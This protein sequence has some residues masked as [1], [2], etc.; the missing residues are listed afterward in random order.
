M[1]SLRKLVTLALRPRAL[2]TPSTTILPRTHLLP[3]NAHRSFTCTTRLRQVSQQEKQPAAEPK[4]ESLKEAVRANEDWIAAAAASRTVDA[5]PEDVDEVNPVTPALRANR[6]AGRNAGSSGRERKEGSDRRVQD[7]PRRQSV[8][9]KPEESERSPASKSDQAQSPLAPYNRLME[10][11]PEQLSKVSQGELI[12][13]LRN[14][15]VLSYPSPFIAEKMSQLLDHIEKAGLPL[16]EAMLSYL[17]SVYAD[18]GNV[19]KTEEVFQHAKA[20]GMRPLNS[21]VVFRGRAKGYSGDLAGAEECVRQ[22]A[23]GIGSGG[24]VSAQRAGE[25]APAL[26]G[27]FQSV[28]RYANRTDSNEAMEWVLRIAETFDVTF[29]ERTFNQLVHW[30]VSKQDLDK[31]LLFLRQ[32]HAMGFPS[33]KY[34]YTLVMKLAVKGTPAATPAPADA[35]SVPAA[36]EAKVEKVKYPKLALELYREMMASDVSIDG[37]LLALVL[38]SYALLDDHASAFR[39]VHKY[40]GGTKKFDYEDYQRFFAMAVVRA[41]PEIFDDLMGYYEKVCP[42]QKTLWVVLEDLVRG[43]PTLTTSDPD[44]ILISKAFKTYLQQTP[45]AKRSFKAFVA[46]IRSLTTRGKDDE[47]LKVL[48]SYEEILPSQVHYGYNTFIGHKALQGKKDE[49]FALLDEMKRKQIRVEANA[50]GLAI[51]AVWQSGPLNDDVKKLL[52]SFRECFFSHPLRQAQAKAAELVGKLKPL[53]LAFEEIGG[54]DYRKGVERFFS[55]ARDK[56]LTRHGMLSGKKAAE[57]HAPLSAPT[58]LPAEPD[59]DLSAFDER[60]WKDE[61]AT[62][63]GDGA[64]GGQASGVSQEPLKLKSPLEHLQ[65]SVT[66]VEEADSITDA[67]I[68][69][70]ADEEATAFSKLFNQSVAKIEKETVQILSTDDKSYESFDKHFRGLRSEMAESLKTSLYDMELA[71]KERLR[72]EE[73]RKRL[74]EEEEI[75]RRHE[76]MAKAARAKVSARE[77]AIA[78]GGSGQIPI[79]YLTKRIDFKGLPG[80]LTTKIS[81]DRLEHSI[82]ATQIRFLDYLNG[83]MADLGQSDVFGGMLAA[84]SSYDVKHEWDQIHAYSKLISKERYNRTDFVQLGRRARSVYILYSVLYDKPELLPIL[85]TGGIELTNRTA[86]VYFTKDLQA[87]M[88]DIGEQ[89]YWWLKPKF[90]NLHDLHTYPSGRGIV[91]AVGNNHFEM[92]LSTIASLRLVLGI[93]LPIEVWYAG[94]SDLS[95]ADVKLLSRFK[96]VR[97]M[98]IWEYFD[99]EAKEIGG[100]AI[101]PWAVLASSFKEVIL[102]DAE[103]NFLQNPESVIERSEIFRKYGQLFYRDRTTGSSQ[104]KWFKSFISYPSNYAKN[105]RYLQGK[106]WHEMES[107]VV[108]VDKGR[109]GVFHGLLATCKLNSKIERDEN[110]YKY[111][112]G[113]KE[114]FWIS[115]EMMRVPYH[116]NPSYGGA[117]GYKDDRGAVCGGLYH[118]DENRKPFWWNGGVVSNKNQGANLYLDF[119]Y[120]AADVKASEVRWEWETDTRPF[121][122]TYENNS[123][124]PTELSDS[125]K[126]LASKYVLLYKDL[127]E[128]GVDQWLSSYPSLL[129]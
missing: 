45:V 2:P 18:H 5:V 32:K 87:L 67:F 38:E 54:G 75:R 82:D 12:R 76:E 27:I 23:G 37:K 89:L 26:N 21:E 119:K 16:N 59:Y 128:K 129:L 14:L 108:I 91:M 66:L 105:G 74:I 123:G 97:A 103:V 98:D 71:E 125:E 94:P 83:E 52:G 1:L 113:D 64:P 70:A 99:D 69:S 124:S 22:I 9:S 24:A 10:M 106:S 7:Q 102:I 34:L 101:K 126:I 20:L 85:A 25:I 95:P 55:E 44:G 13:T 30:Y 6:N 118:V 78:A 90:S 115:W 72:H 84:D 68:M 122:I 100:W 104:G 17:A 53:R 3:T 8:N 47:A 81:E 93:N 36:G 65:S 88:K 49:V 58:P 117:I 110:T 127:K 80:S 73:L 31:A 112:Y 33:N 120:A 11:S 4:E 114:T 62:L 61:S 111:V 79:G 43:M 29:D 15:K 107:G 56:F 109:T 48:R 92:A 116:F 51:P 63:A 77:Q 121:C 28:A 40:R 96:G 42:N 41:G 35:A 57:Q 50:Y 19:E 86:V 46:V 60:R 39:L